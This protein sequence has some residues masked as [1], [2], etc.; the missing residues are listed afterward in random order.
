MVN[1]NYRNLNVFR[2]KTNKSG[3]SQLTLTTDNSAIPIINY[4][5]DTGLHGTGFSKNYTDTSLKTVSIFSNQI[6]KIS[7]III[8]ATNPVQFYNE[9]DLLKLSRLYILNFSNGINPKLH[10]ILF[11]NS[12]DLSANNVTNFTIN[13]TAINGL[14]DYSGQFNIAGVI[15]VNSNPNLNFVKSPIKKTSGNVVSTITFSGSTTSQNLLGYLDL[16]LYDYIT[17]AITTNGNPNLY[18]VIFPSVTN[19]LNNGSHVIADSTLAPRSKMGGV[20]DISTLLEFGQISVTDSSIRNIYFP[21]HTKKTSGISNLNFANNNL[22]GLVDMSGIRYYD[23]ITFSSYNL[24]YLF[25]NRQS[26]VSSRFNLNLDNNIQGTLDLEGMIGTYIFT[27][28][29]SNNGFLLLN[30]NNIV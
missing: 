15:G 29:T 4:G 26:V 16:S 21:N 23:D 9:L 22:L 5:D 13:T 8:N 12:I 25:F 14:V 10:S 28:T 19:S 7:G 1:T 27:T 6:K 20:L 3:L 17:G 18:N 11:R 24:N 30:C 2:F